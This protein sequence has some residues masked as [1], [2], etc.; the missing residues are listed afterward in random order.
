MKR[1]SIINKLL[2]SVNL[3]LLIIFISGCEKA[4]EVDL[5]INTITAESVF[6][7]KSTAAAAL[8]N[9]YST[10]SNSGLLAG[11]GGLSIRVGLMADELIPVNPLVY[12]E[13]TNIADA[14]GK[15]WT[16]WS[17]AYSSI[18]YQIN[19]IIGGVENSN[20][21]SQATKST[22]TGEAKFLRAWMYFSLVNFYGDVPL[23]L[24]T[25]YRINAQIARSKTSD[26]YSQIIIDLKE[27]RDNLE[28]E[29]LDKDLIS[30]VPD[31]IRANRSVASALLARVYLYAGEWQL[32]ADEATKLIE[33]AKYELLTDLNQVFLKNSKETIWALQPNF[34]DASGV[35]TPD[36][37]YLINPFNIAPFYSL[38][39]FLVNAFEP[40]DN[41]KTSWVTTSDGRNISFK[42]KEGWQTMESKEYTIVLR[43]SEQYLIRAEANMHLD[44]LTEATNDLNII[45][46]RAGLTDFPESDESLLLTA[47]LKERQVELFLEWG[48]RWMDLNRTNTMN[49]VMAVVAPVKGASWAEYKSLLPIPAYEFRYNGSLRGHQNPGYFEQ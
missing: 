29:Y 2:L 47:I 48:Q 21:L 19:S 34:T 44:K 30:I 27:A 14:N 25:D 13:Y 31:R 26:V 16:V 37:K 41:R 43:L 5:P 28:D 40:D 7:E 12:P 3:S 35:N 8:T 22:L 15:G 20:T 6:K 42:Y 23:V 1:K 11:D 39:D 33:S 38:S 32:A 9:V 24:T 18:L 45:R 4:L 17:E 10:L 49:E 36:G 46:R